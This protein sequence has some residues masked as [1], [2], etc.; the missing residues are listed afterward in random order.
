MLR[1]I[2]G[3]I[4]AIDDPKDKDTLIEMGNAVRREFGPDILVR[5]A[6]TLAERINDD[7]EHR[8]TVVDSLRNP[9][10]V[11][12]LKQETNAT[13]VE[14]AASE[15]LRLFR[16]QTRGKPGD[17][18]TMEELRRMDDIDRGIGQEVTG[19][20]I[21]GCVALADA[22]IVNEGSKSE[23]GRE[24]DNLLVCRGLTEGHHGIEVF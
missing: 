18:T 21:A 9:A 11:N 17:P 4:K 19:Q 20:N 24:L 14:V 1:R 8:G 6:K 23:L 5:A 13:I 16:L 22:S 10:E 3:S 15:E 2:A 12:F 7:P